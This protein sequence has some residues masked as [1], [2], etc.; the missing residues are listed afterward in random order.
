MGKCPSE[1][2]RVMSDVDSKAPLIEHLAELRK[3]VM[4]IVFAWLA[5]FVGCYL[6]IDTIYAFL[7]ELLADS[8]ADASDRRLIYT[9]LT[10]TF[11]TY[12][13]LALY[14]AFFVAF[15]VIASQFYMFLAPGLYDRE[16]FVMIPYLIISPLLFFAGAALAYCYVM[17]MAWKF[18]IGFES[19]SATIGLPIYL[20]AKVSEYLSLVVQILF[21]FGIAFQ[22]PV[23]LTLM[24][25][26]G[27]V[28]TQTLKKSRKYAVVAIITA[29][30]FL[31]PP[32]IISQ[33]ALFIPLYLLYEISI[34]MCGIMEKRH[35]E[36]EIQDGELDHA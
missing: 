19:P 28:R 22:L 33:I 9:S 8:F 24:A 14:A 6:Y 10:E 35:E 7:V 13:K 30:A 32:D 31:T 5:A 23:V 17:P 12:V 27:M 15:P 1:M 2:V 34:L 21:A 3:R 18:F 11:F 29:A 25:R 36:A 16:K 26:A 20:E 4:I